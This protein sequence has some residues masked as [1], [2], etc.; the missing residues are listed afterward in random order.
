[1]LHHDSNDNRFPRL[2]LILP[3]FFLCSL[4]WAV[5]VSAEEKLTIVQR[6]ASRGTLQL[7]VQQPASLREPL[8]GGAPAIQSLARAESPVVLAQ[9]F[10]ER[11][12]PEIGINAPAEAL[13]LARVESNGLGITQV[14]Y[15]QVVKDVPVY[16]A[17][18][19]VT[20]AQD[21]AVSSSYG[22]ISKL[23]AINTVPGLSKE[24]AVGA[25]HALWSSSLGV[26]GTVQGEPKLYVLD[27]ALFN[28][29]KATQLF[30]VWDVVLF[31]DS[32]SHG[33][34]FFIDAHSG[35]LRHTHSLIRTLNRQVYD[36]SFGDGQCYLDA[37]DPSSGF[38]FGRSEGNPAVGP[39]PFH[40]GLESI[41]TDQ[42]YDSLGFAHNY[43]ASS[44]GRNGAN[45]VGGIG[46]GVATDPGATIAG[47]YA[48]DAPTH[49]FFGITG[50]P[51]A[52]WSPLQGRLTFCAGLALIDIVGHEYTH[53]VEHYSIR[54]P[55]GEF[56]G[57]DGEYEPGALSEGYSDLFGEAIERFA[58]GQ[59]DWIV[60]S[61]GGSPSGS[62]PVRNLANPE[63]MN[64][65][66]SLYSPNYFCGTGDSGGIHTNAT[67]VGHAAYRIAV[68]GAEN[69]CSNSGI[70]ESAQ[71]RIFYRALTAYS[72]PL[73]NFSSAYAG[74][75]LACNDLY[76]INS[77]QCLQTA[78]AL[79][80]LQMNQPGRCSGVPAATIDCDQCPLDPQKSAPGICGCGVGDGDANGNG[81]PDC[82]DIQV[83]GILPV[84]PSV[85]PGRRQLTFSLQPRP[86]LSYLIRIEVLPTSKRGKSK[87]LFY[88][89]KV[90]SGAIKKLPSGRI[91][92]VSY[93][94]VLQGTTP[95]YSKLSASKR[96]RIR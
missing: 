23:G 92:G 93:A 21:G 1:M 36:C 72:S 63:S 91:V 96:A 88:L 52:N 69:G 87:V 20:L 89:S 78:K 85:K 3:R 95:L 80:S 79:N 15:N 49:P 82:N 16:G 39:H 74:I 2:S 77:D 32:R 51:N 67:V 43:F 70:G 11:H 71:E 65:P 44:F 31:S 7:T 40:T 54:L 73:S 41:D 61:I 19:L 76:G 60:G 83:Q 90:S 84:A 35:E 81:I 50:C 30:L 42:I 13:T 58:T 86:G 37:V 33:Y 28:S 5:G 66:N 46:N 48:G 22:R 29:N 68:G 45:G 24:D 12:G 56:F 6:P 10:L 55:T 62:V 94:Y 18:L 57:F 75:L 8:M 4:L 34:H 25:A 9:Q 27:R 59:H 47:S 17:E 26:G 14:R 64:L 38:V 53:A